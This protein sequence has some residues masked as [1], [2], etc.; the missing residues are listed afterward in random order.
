MKPTGMTSLW[1]ALHLAH[2]KLEEKARTF[3]NA[4]KRIVVLTDG[5]DTGSKIWSPAVACGFLQ[6]GFR[7]RK[8]DLRM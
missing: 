4:V 8:K 6:V 7:S 2:Q 3:P 5:E 1:D